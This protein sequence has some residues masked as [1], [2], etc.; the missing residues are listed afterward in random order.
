MQGARWHRLFHSLTGRPTE[1]PARQEVEVQVGNGLS[2]VP[3]IVDH[4]PE[5]IFT[6]SLLLRDN[7]YASEKVSKKILIRGIGLSDPD[8][9]LFRHEEQ[10]HRGLGSDVPEAE[11]QVVLVDDISR[12]LPIRNLLED[13]FFSHGKIAVLRTEAEAPSEATR[14]PSLSS[15]RG[16]SVALKG[17]W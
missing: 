5:A 14:E 17:Q 4:H 15:S 11:A 6:Q 12:N 7:A 3:A 10:V 1:F 8:D 2:S 9:Q 16:Y 13:G